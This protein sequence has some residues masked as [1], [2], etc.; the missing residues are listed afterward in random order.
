M[1]E[2]DPVTRDKSKG[3]KAYKASVCPKRHVRPHPQRRRRTLADPDV[4]FPYHEANLKNGRI[5]Q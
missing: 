5:A 1:R 2:E 3:R 4:V